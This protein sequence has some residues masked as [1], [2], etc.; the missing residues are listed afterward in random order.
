MN[1]ILSALGRLNED[2]SATIQL[3]LRPIDDDWQGTIKKMIRKEEK[4]P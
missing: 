3:L 2:T 4:N 1:A